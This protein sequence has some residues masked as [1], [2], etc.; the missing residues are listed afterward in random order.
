MKMRLNSLLIATVI[1][2]VYLF[3]GCHF[4]ICNITQMLLEWHSV[5][6]FVTL[7]M[8]VFLTVNAFLLQR[9]ILIK[10]RVLTFY[11]IIKVP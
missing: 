5:D 1:A 2:S 3:G 11:F 8:G 9:F 7:S 6:I 4:L 10:T